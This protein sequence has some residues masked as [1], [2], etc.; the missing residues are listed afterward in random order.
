MGP[1]FRV[2]AHGGVSPT[3]PRL[4]GRHVEKGSILGRPMGPLWGSKVGTLEGQKSGKIPKNG[5]F[6]TFGHFWRKPGF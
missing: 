5:T 1:K 2:W 3:G 6:G 4:M